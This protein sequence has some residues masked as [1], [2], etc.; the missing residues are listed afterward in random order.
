MTQIASDTEHNNQPVS[1]AADPSV[2]PAGESAI[3]KGEDALSL[4][5][6]LNE[7]AFYV[8]ST[9]RKPLKC[10][11]KYIGLHSS[12][13]VLFETPELSQ[14][15]FQLYFQKGAPVKACALSQRGEGARIYF[16]SQIEFIMPMEGTGKS[17]IAVGL[18][19]S[20]DVVHGLR[21]E[22]RLEISVAGILDPETHKH[23]CQIR[24]FSANGCQIFIDKKHT[25][26]KL[27]DKID[28]QFVDSPDGD[29]SL[30]L[31]GVVK[32]KKRSNQYW[33]YGVQFDDES[34]E[35]ATELMDKL[36]FDES[37]VRYLL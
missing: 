33:K 31:H 22:A 30:I 18:P 17:I 14:E 16:R 6:S 34:R 4:V 8:A 10:R 7:I 35:K 32:N 20:A 24:D 36:S 9:G 1:P 21:S 5:S 37:Q 12:N 25:N 3:L 2:S 13:F 26:Y 27:G 11:S 19:A 23:P 28:I 15:Q 29:E